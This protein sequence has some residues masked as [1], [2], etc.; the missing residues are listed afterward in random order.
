VREIILTDI[1]GCYDE[2]RSLLKEVDFGRGDIIVGASDAVD[3][4]PESAQVV[5]FLR[6]LDRDG[7]LV[8]IKGNHEVKFVKFA[9]KYKKDPLRALEHKYAAHMLRTLNALD[10]SDVEWLSQAALWAPLTQFKGLV[11]HAG[12]EPDMRRLPPAGKV[13]DSE[14]EGANALIYCRYVKNGKMVR[15]GSEDDSCQFWADIY[16]GRWGHVFYGHQSWLMDE[17]RLTSNTSGLDLGCVIGGRLAAAVSEG[18]KVYYASVPGAQYAAP[19]KK[20]T[21]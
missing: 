2:L 12:F 4:G 15:L 5:R 20:E 18:G 21:K 7:Q 1:H 11:V 9:E 13:T 10:D 19:Y 3:K 6:K 17:P 14:V 8:R 16:D